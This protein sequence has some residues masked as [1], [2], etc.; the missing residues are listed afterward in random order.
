MAYRYQVWIIPNGQITASL[1]KTENVQGLPGISG[2]FRTR[3]RNV[4]GQNPTHNASAGWMSLEEVAF[5]LAN[6]DP[7]FMVYEP[8]AGQQPESPHVTIARLG[9]AMYQEPA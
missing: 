7:S 8:A 9:Y 6:L 4:A 2:M 3:L 5:L 1:A